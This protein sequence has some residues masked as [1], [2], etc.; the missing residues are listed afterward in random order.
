MTEQEGTASGKKSKTSGRTKSIVAWRKVTKPKR[1]GGLGVVDLEA[2]ND[3]LLLKHLDKFYNKNDVL[4][5]NMIWHSHYS[6]GH[7]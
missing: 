5:V 3:A 4:W 2:Q 7:I 6:Q 1:K